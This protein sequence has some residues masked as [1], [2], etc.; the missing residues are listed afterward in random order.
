MLAELLWAPVSARPCSSWFDPVLFISF[1]LRLQPN[2][3]IASD[4]TVILGY[5]SEGISRVVTLMF[6]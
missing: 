5:V 6:F 4:I 3:A 1:L 2:E